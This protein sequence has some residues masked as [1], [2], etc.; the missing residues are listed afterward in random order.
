VRRKFKGQLPMPNVGYG[1]NNKTKHIMP[2]GFLKFV[3]HNVKDLELLMMHNRKWVSLGTC[4]SR[5][6]LPRSLASHVFDMRVHVHV[7]TIGGGSWR[8]VHHRVT[9]QRCAHVWVHPSCGP[10]RSTGVGLQ[11]GASVSSCC[12]ACRRHAA[13]QRPWRRPWRGDPCRRYAGEVAHN[14]S[15]LK[16]KSIVERAAQLNIKLTNGAARL[17]SQE[18]E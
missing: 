6:S 16:R 1:S 3:V 12:K 13:S 18:D 14:V 8:A 11:P 9:R 17:R 7:P 15:T 4:C 2:S 10:R 5:R